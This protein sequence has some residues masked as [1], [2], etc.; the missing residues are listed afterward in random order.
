MSKLRSLHT[1][2]LTC[3]VCPLGCSISVKL[4]GLE[5]I[6]VDG[7]TC[8]KGEAYARDEV[9]YP[10]RT[11]TSSV[12][13]IGGSWPLVSV[14]TSGPIPKA[15]IPAV[16]RALKAK[17]VKAPVK[18]GAVMIKNVAMTGVDIIATRDV[19]KAHRS[20]P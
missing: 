9:L 15:K 7:N 13:V 11:L 17:T 3:I 4:K 5:V 1:R 12:L 6:G 2:N 16:M 19:G 20:R 14:R 10:K 8:A 18:M